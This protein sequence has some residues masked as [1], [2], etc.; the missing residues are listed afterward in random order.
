VKRR[1]RELA[2]DVE[3]T[4]RQVVSQRSA[5]LG[6]RVRPDDVR[7]S[8]FDGEAPAGC[9]LF[10]AA[11]GGGPTEGAL[12]GLI[13]DGEP[14]DTYPVQALGKVFRRWLDSGEV[15]DAVAMA[16]VVAYLYDPMDS[17]PLVLRPGDV[18]A[19]HR[20]R[21]WA[22]YL[23][24]PRIVDRDGPRG[25]VF[26]WMGER[27]PAQLSVALDESG[28]VETVQRTIDSLLAEESS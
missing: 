9:T 7:V 25:V 17:C 8:V 12:S 15:P 20:R 28:E 23:R 4:V 27:G 19:S 11:W 26:W 24:P 22:P 5:E 2:G 18:V 6:G 3:A 21:D 10:H 16:S 14:P 13:R 1:R